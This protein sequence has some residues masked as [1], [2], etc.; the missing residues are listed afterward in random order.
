MKKIRCVL[1]PTE[2]NSMFGIAPVDDSF[3]PSTE[4]LEAL[5]ENF[6]K[7]GLYKNIVLG[8]VELN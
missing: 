1:F 8:F 2:I 4:S 6:R 5:I 7:E 3:L